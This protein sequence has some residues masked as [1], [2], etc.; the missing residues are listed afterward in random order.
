MLAKRATLALLAVRALSLSALASPA[1]DLGL[2]TVQDS[3]F[4]ALDSDAAS[5]CTDTESANSPNGNPEVR[6]DEGLFVGYRRA[7][8]DHFLGIPFALPP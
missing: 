1:Q 7:Q 6:L 4:H 5:I 3:N 2:F 8:T